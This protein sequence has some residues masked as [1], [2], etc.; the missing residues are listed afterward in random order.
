MGQRGQKFTDESRRE[1]VRLARDPKRSVKTL[2]LELGVSVTSLR[3][4]MRTV[5]L[6]KQSALGYR[7]PVQF[8][9]QVLMAG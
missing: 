3:N 9:E 5:S 2:A 6:E 1:A 7:T 4:W 8:E